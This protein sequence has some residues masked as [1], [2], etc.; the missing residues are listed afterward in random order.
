MNATVADVLRGD[1]RWCVVEGDAL[2][3]LRDLAPSSVDA[4][5]MDPPYCSGGVSEA[6]RSSAKG[7]GLRS[8]TIKRFGWFVGDNMGTAG[9]V[10]LLRSVAFA[11]LAVCKESASMLCFADWRMVPSIAPAI[12]SSGWRYQNLVVWNKG[13][14]G[15]GAGFRAQ[16]EMVIHLTAG[17]P[18]YHDLGTSNVITVP[19]ESREEREHQTQKPVD[20][21]RRLIRVVA[22]RG[23]LVLDPFAGS[24]TTGVAALSE[25]RRV[26]LCERDPEHAATAR[27]RCEAAVAGT[28][29]RRPEQASLFGGTP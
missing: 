22:P 1:A 12:E 21:M 13:A 24:G 2:D 19:R 7:Q 15:L 6:S 20:L 14:V 11:S 9:L 27:A 29:W 4:V 17:S 10:W 26:I 16:H 18:E 28:D 5:V 8:E 23:G 3:V 25:G